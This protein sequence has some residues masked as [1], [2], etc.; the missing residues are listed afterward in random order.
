MVTGNDAG[1]RARWEVVWVKDHRL[2]RVG[3]GDDFGEA[4][5][6]YTLAVQSLGRTSVTLRC[7]NMGFPPP[8]RLRTRMVTFDKPRRLKDGTKVTELQVI[9]M[10][11][12]NREG[13]WWCPF[14][15]KLRR[16][17][18]V[19][20]WTTQEGVWVAE[21]KM[22]CPMCNV[23]H[24]SFEVRRWNPRASE[25]FYSQDVR[26][27]TKPPRRTRRRRKRTTEEE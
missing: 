5:R 18:F 17:K 2:H 15:I 22:V 27:P 26:D 12:M 25:L 11:K 7:K 13:V 14:C 10:R 3:T 1:T 21:P 8:E 16:F 20:G 6:L 9:P 23:D 24:T 19:K 4:L